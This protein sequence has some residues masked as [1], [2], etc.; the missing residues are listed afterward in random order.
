MKKAYIKELQGQLLGTVTD[1]PDAL[2]H[3]ATD[4]SVLRAE[5]GSVVYP[6]NTAD[7]RKTVQFAYEHALAG[8]PVPLVARG[9]GAGV[10]GG[11]LGAGTHVVFSAHMNKLLRLEHDTVTV[12]PGISYRTLQQTLHT[13]NRFIP[14]HPTSLD[15]TTVGGAVA[16]DAVGLH[17]VKYGSTRQ[18]VKC[19]KV[20]LSDGS[21]IETGRISARELNRRKGLSTLEGQLYRGLDNILLDNAEFI[22]KHT[23]KLPYNAAGYALEHVRGR[24][25][26]FDIGQIFIGAQGTLGFI[27]E[28]TLRTAVYHP[29]TTLVVGFF[30]STYAALDAAT[31]LRAL[32][33]SA[34]ELA[35]RAL[36]EAVLAS[37]PGY[38]DG[39][40][41]DD[42]PYTVVLTQFD[43]ASQFSQKLAAARAERV[44]EKFKGRHR[45]SSDPVEQ[46]ALWKLRLAGSR[47][48][49]PANGQKRAVPFLEAAVVPLPKLGA[50]LDKTTKLLKQYDAMAVIWGHVGDGNLSFMPRLDLSKKK[51]ADRLLNLSRDYAELVASLGGTPSGTAGDGPLRSLWLDKVYGDELV[52]LFAA[53]KHVFDPHNVFGPGQKTNADPAAVRAA[54]RT[55]YVNTTQHN[56]MMF[57]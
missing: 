46:V 41:P 18:F 4:L 28:V 16:E 30:D 6:A 52:K 3:F 27:T 39:L 36:M 23:L 24:D 33:P 50:L 35:D 49:E 15:C 31:K 10:S 7:V 47:Y 14:P 17:A 54:L 38:L 22:R 29:R 11:A 8:R 32:G 1:N 53:V 56:Y 51:D 42:K 48:M 55:E 25:G 13:H 20:V 5:P 57:H 43:Q 34:L 45:T 37:H 19:L 12:Q 44:I 9:L 40:L 2:A 26:S 21:I